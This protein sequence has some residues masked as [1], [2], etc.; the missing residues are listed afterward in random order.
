M[1]GEKLLVSVPDT[2]AQ[3]GG[4][5]RTTVYELVNNGE[6]VKVNIGRRGFIT[7][8]SLSAYVERLSEA[9]SA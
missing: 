9:A 1:P 4:V 2:C 7:A 3:L 6:L 8:K 5:S